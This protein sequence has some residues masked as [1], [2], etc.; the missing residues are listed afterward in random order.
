MQAAIRELRSH[1]PRAAPN[2]GNE[3]ETVQPLDKDPVGKKEAKAEIALLKK[4]VDDSVKHTKINL[5]SNDAKVLNYLTSE[6]FEL[7]CAVHLSHAIFEQNVSNDIVQAFP[8]DT[9]QNLRESDVKIQFPDKAS[10][11]LTDFEILI[12]DVPYK[13]SVKKVTFGISSNTVKFKDLFRT[14]YEVEVWAKKNKDSEGQKIIAKSAMEVY[15][16]GKYSNRNVIGIPIL[17]ILN[18][19]RD[20]NKIVK[21]SIKDKLQLGNHFIFPFQKILEKIKLAYNFFLALF[22]IRI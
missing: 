5:S 21:E 19:L 13:I 16:S 6:F 4:I 14:P 17:S 18:L 9:I 12:K 3:K 11:A 7:L 1:E 20:D 2:Y 10:N 15:K 8:P 22:M